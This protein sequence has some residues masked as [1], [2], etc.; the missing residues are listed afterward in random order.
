MLR[1]LVRLAIGIPA[2]ALLSL[3]AP[4]LAQ[5][6]TLGQGAAVTSIDPHFHNLAT[7]I[8]LSIHMFDRLVDQDERMR[9]IPGLATEWKTI[10]DT[11]WEFKL[12]PGVK[13]HD[14][15]DLSAEDVAATIR[16]VNWVPNSPSPFTI[17]TRQIKEIIVVDPQ[18]IRFKTSTPYPLMPVDLASI[19]IVSRKF[20]QAPTSAFNDGSAMIGSGPFKYASYAQGDRI[21]V[22]RND[23]YWGAKPHWQKA[24]IK[25][26][27]NNA[28][29][30]AALLAGDVQ[31]IDDVPP[32]DYVAL[33]ANANV[34]LVRA[35]ANS[36]LFI[37]MDSF[38]DK[39]PFVTDK[40]GQPLAANPFKDRRVRMAISKAI[41]RQALVERV[42][43]GTATPAGGLLAEGFFGVSPK[44]K[45][46][47]YDPDGARKLLAEAGYP[48]GFAITIHG[49]NDR[50]PNDDK[51]LQALAPMLTRIGIDTKVVA[52]PWTIFIGQASAPTYAYSLLLIG[53]SATTGE[54]SFPLRA[55]VATVSSEKGMG[56]SNRAR[57][58]NPKVDEVLDR[59]LATVDD[60]KREA[61]LQ[62]TAEIAMA[63][64]AL[65]PLFYQDN[66]YALRK[67]LAYTGRADGYMAAFM[68][69]PGN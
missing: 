55:Q 14:G 53:N 56:A 39:T 28:A 63:D 31:A 25:I 62:E 33:K 1:A 68:I 43:D 36:V 13:F 38:R 37:H 9:P 66:T 40:A 60:K 58:S 10:D 34:S 7:N 20:E 45:P 54:A 19:Y 64:Q 51:V 44:L 30:V 8:K 29:R 15:S 69:R 17:Y 59:A 47:A 12:R 23:A 6:I 32:A 4:S 11:T 41:N 16:R 61:L 26:I 42:M 21:V 50:Y 46:D 2:A 35:L 57:Y 52:Q 27:T 49:P 24:T 65:V 67:G 48:N 22:Q 5:E 18:T 3:A